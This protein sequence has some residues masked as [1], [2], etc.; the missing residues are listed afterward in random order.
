MHPNNLQIGYSHRGKT[1]EVYSMCSEV[2][3]I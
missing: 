1:N 2:E 3:N